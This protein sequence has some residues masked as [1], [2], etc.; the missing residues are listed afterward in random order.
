MVSIMAHGLTCHHL[1]HTRQGNI[2]LSKQTVGNLEPLREQNTEINMVRSGGT[3]GKKAHN[4]S[5]GTRGFNWSGV[6]LHHMLSTAERRIFEPSGNALPGTLM[7]ILSFL[8][9]SEK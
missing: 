4:S 6:G 7:M 9:F 3:W 2:V 5:R 1:L 8:Y